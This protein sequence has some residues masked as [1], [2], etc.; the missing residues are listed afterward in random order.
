MRTGRLVTLKKFCNF[1]LQEDVRVFVLLSLKVKFLLQ[2]TQT[3]TQLLN[4]FLIFF[5]GL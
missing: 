2:V 5:D 4:F 3:P 1:F